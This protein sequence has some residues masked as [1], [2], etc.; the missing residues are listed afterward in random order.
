MSKEEVTIEMMQYDQLLHHRHI[1]I[2]MKNPLLIL[3]SMSGSNQT[4][5][6]QLRFM[7]LMVDYHIRMSMPDIND[8]DYFPPV[9]EL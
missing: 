5:M 7:V 2:K 1:F 3:L 8:E 4:H 9:T 6:D